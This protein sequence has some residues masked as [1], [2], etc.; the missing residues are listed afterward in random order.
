MTGLVLLTVQGAFPHTDAAGVVT[1]QEHV[2]SSD[3]RGFDMTSAAFGAAF[4]IQLLGTIT[5]GQ[6][7]ASLALIL[8][9]FTTL[10]TW[11]YYGERAITYLFGQSL[12]I[13]WRLLWCLMAFVGA[14]QEID[15]V[16]RTGDIANAAMAFPNLIALA[17]LSGVVIKLAKGDR[18]AGV[19]HGGH[20]DART[21]PAAE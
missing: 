1:M 13:P 17:L 4:P 9:A 15:L 11:G 5:I 10:I 21:P 16:W 3:L 12:A 8:F 14:F 7:V 18:M 2:W 20:G 19:D 6:L